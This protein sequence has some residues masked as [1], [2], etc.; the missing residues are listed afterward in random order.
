M[1]LHTATRSTDDMT[2]VDNR[3]MNGSP[4]GR[5]RALHVDRDSATAAWT[6]QPCSD[7]RHSTVLIVQPAVWPKPTKASSLPSPSVRFVDCLSRFIRM[8]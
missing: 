4:P 8:H 6:N 7:A 3:R 2:S 5:D 1:R